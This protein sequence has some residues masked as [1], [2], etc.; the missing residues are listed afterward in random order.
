M[1]MTFKEVAEMYVQQPTKKFARKQKHCLQIVEKICARLGDQPISK[2]ERKRPVL[3]YITSVRNQPSMRRVG[4]LVSNGY[5]NSHIVFL[6]A[7]LVFARDELEI[8]DRVPLIK[9]LSEKK[10]DT[11]LT[12][13]QVRN[14]MRWLDELRADMVEFAVNTGLRNSNVR[15]LKWSEL[16]DDFSALHVKAEDSKNGEPTA[17]PLNKDAQRVLKRR[18]AKRLY[19]EDRYPYLKGK[20]DH[21]FAKE[22]RRRSANGKP[23][24]DCKAISGTRWREACRNAGLPDDVVFHTLRHTFASWHLQS[25]TSESTLQELGNWQSE[26]SMKRYGHLSMKFKKDAAAN[27]SGLLRSTL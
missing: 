11:Y 9:T 25:G 24:A 20:V 22:C 14:L 3:E 6:R 15:L 18:H 2:F 7:I 16:A 26:R 23:Y 10:R 21:V 19:L 8:I 1:S 4:Q 12:P 5:V 27:I 17:I 13:E